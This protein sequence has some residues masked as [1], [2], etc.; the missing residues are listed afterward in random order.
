MADQIYKQLLKGEIVLEDQTEAVIAS[1]KNRKKQALNAIK[2]Q[3]I[4]NAAALTP[5][6]T[7]NLRRSI[8]GEVN[9]DEDYVIIGTNVEYAPSVEMGS[10]RNKHPAHMLQKAATEGEY[11][12]QYKQIVETAFAKD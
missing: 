2:S 9:E 11:V 7:G 6:V 5:V 4:K 12:A 10:S 3:A 1:F 8:T